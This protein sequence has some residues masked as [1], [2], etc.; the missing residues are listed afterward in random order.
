MTLTLTDAPVL[1]AELI[2]L[3]PERRLHHL[4]ATGPPEALLLALGDE[5]HR[6][7]TVETGRALAASEMVV[8]LATAVGA[9]RARARALRAHAHALAHA[10]RFVEALAAAEAAATVAAAAGDV[11]ECARARLAAV[12]PLSSLARYDEAIAA[13][14]EARQAFLAAG[15]PALA[16]RADVSLGATHD[17]RD[18]PAT[19]LRHYDRAR[20]ELADEPA[21]I[22]QLD[23]NRGVALTSVDD[24]AGAE[25]AFGAAV[26]AFAAEGQTWAA[27]IAEGNLAYLAARQGR[28]ER[29]LR[30][31]ERARRCLEEDESRADL[32]RVLAEQADVF[33]VLGLADDALAAY[34]RALPVL[35]EYGFAV[36]AAQ[37]RAG[38]GRVLLRLGRLDDADRV[39]TEATAA[40]AA[41]GHATAGA[42]L[43][44]VRAELAAAQGRPAEARALVGDALTFFTDRPVEA[45]IARHHLARLALAAGDLEAADA[46]LRAAV[47]AAERYDLPPLLADLFHVR[48]LVHR[49]RGEPDRAVAD[50]R[51][52]VEQIERVRGTLQAERFRAAFLGNRLAVYEDL[53]RHALDRGGAGAIAEAFATVELAKSRALLDLVGGALDLAET[54][55]AG[56]TDPSEAALVAEATQVRAELNWL[57]SRLAEA[58]AVGQGGRHPDDA[59]WREALH[60]RERELDAMQARLAAARGTVGLHAP[61]ID[62]AGARRLI[63]TDAALIE[64]F[65]A[66]EDVL[67]FVLRP[68]G[69]ARVYRGLATTAEL[70]DR[71]RRVQFQINR[72]TVAAARGGGRADRLAADARRELGALDECLLAPLRPALAGVNRLIVVPHGPLH[73]VPFQALWD[74]ECHLI[75]RCEV[76]VVPSASLL[77]QLRAA[78]PPPAP[79]QAALVVGVPD[80]IAP[81]MGEEALR[82]ARTLGTDR[83]LLGA[84]ATVERVMA[85]A[86]DV[87]VL[88]LACH[89]RFSAESPLA[90]GLKLA[91]RWLTVRDVYTLRL[92]GSLVTLSGCDTGRSAVGRG[93]ELAGLLRSFF[94][95]GARALVVSLW[96]ANDSSAA[97]L[98]THFYA[99]WRAGVTI[100][101]AMRSAQCALLAQQPHPAAWAPFVVGGNP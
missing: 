28:L 1:L 98:M 44:L 99:S 4:G 19:A 54:D 18:D 62:L 38:L 89:G 34:E 56:V 43:D 33:A 16:A 35:E 20:L 70:G 74:G 45:A 41:L 6:L 69:D 80:T 85:A 47:G 83:V 7:A 12:H 63:P 67:A 97:E 9:E 60:A 29:A 24:F 61:P 15:E 64:Y 78:S 11:V 53:V 101:A 49:A 27:A 8:A 90:S 31:F 92:P 66:G 48:G 84:D 50:L 30:H 59:G 73:T 76:V 87:G 55:L 26:A 68:Q 36:E 37:A 2:A 14:E 82:V 77:G 51:A 91:D 3:P 86:G 79:R 96:T 40:L 17:A 39:L 42:R 23:A 46:E 65:V 13:G 94:A 58:D 93:D 72:G 95:A 21:L 25:A 22:A 88:H 57:Y 52:A 81:R 32:A 75:E 71:V 100:P 10:G 5:A